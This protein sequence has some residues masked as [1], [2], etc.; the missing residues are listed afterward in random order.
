MTYSVTHYINEIAH[1]TPFEL[2]FVFGFIIICSLITRRLKQPAVMGCFLGGFLIHSITYFTGLDFTAKL[3]LGPH[4]IMLLISLLIFNEGMHV[5]LEYLLKNIEEILCLSLLGTI[6]A[7]A[8]CGFLLHQ[9]LGF[10]WAVAII[11]GAMLIPTD[12]GAVL[13]VLNDLG[14]SQRWK[15]LIGGE[16]IFNDPFGLIIFGLAL[17]VISGKAISWGVTIALILIGSPLLGIA[18]GYLFYL[19]YK[20]L[21]DPVSELMLSGML[22]LAAHFGAEFLHMSEFLTV[23]LASIFVGNKKHLCMDEETRETLNR[24]WE[25]LAI[26]I[27]GFLFLIIGK[28][29]P[30]EHLFYYLPLG[31]L[32]ITIV[33]AARSI[34]VHSLLW[35]LDRLFKQDVPFKW[36]VIVDLSGLHVGVTMAIMLTL[37]KT[38]PQI[39]NIKVMGYYVITWSVLAMPLFMKFA[40]RKMRLV[41][42]LSSP[43]V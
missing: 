6:I 33:M 21:N 14:V 41:K 30:L 5:D 15:S 1:E 12:A 18:L 39:Q 36:R 26:G 40:L 17:G 7:C 35:I 28:E 20:Q 8:V 42:S 24:V 2:I 22:F 25:A 38:L 19:L 13:A 3:S 32:A 23:A 43:Y 31:L 37:P 16:S 10:G 9:I 4:V 11:T 34:A 27:E 29:I